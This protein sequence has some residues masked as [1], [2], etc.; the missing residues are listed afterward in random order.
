MFLDFDGI[1]NARE[2]G[3][4]AA[5]DGKKVRRNVLLRTGKLSNLSERDG[6][7]L[8][9]EYRLRH[10]V[11]F[12]DAA[13]MERKP[14]IVPEGIEYHPIQVLKKL[15][16]R[17]NEDVQTRPP[18]EVKEIAKNVYRELAASDTAAKGYGE[19]FRIL[20]EARG[21]AVLWH[22]TQG[23][24]RSGA[25]A[26][27]LLA[28]LGAGEDEA[29]E[30][31]YLSNVHAQR[32]YEELRASGLAGDKLACMKNVLFVMPECIGEYTD[33][34]RRQYGGVGDYVRRGIGLTER[35]IRLLRE[36]YTE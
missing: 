32:R 28:A 1:V 23:K 36:Y 7:R 20:L 27:L 22:C 13:E 3:G 26:L 15:P 10:I 5:A 8:A 17:S 6:E 29:M 9:D 24:D 18:K 21:E 30:E 4:I 16:V 14:D 12:R 25:A 34:L 33:A 19:F 31:Y 2:L 35:E 11:D